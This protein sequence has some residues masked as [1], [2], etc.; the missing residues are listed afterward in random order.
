MNQAPA[1]PRP[2]S[3]PGTASGPAAVLRQLSWT[4]AELIIGGALLAAHFLIPAQHD[5]LRSVTGGAAIGSLVVVVMMARFRYEVRGG[6][7]TAREQLRGPRSA[8]LTRLAG[9]TAPDQPEKFW[10]STLFG[11]RR[12]LELRDERGSVVRLSFSG[13]GRG[14]RR[15]LLAAL[16]PYVMADGV[17]RTGLV[18]EALSGELWWPRPRR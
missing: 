5:L 4:V 17:S 10:D 1:E 7:I 16:E 14:P 6:R 18:T 11:Q 15:R 2:A 13:T 9:V 8:D 12:Y 3:T